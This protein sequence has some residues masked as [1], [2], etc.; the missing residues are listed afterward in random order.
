MPTGRLN[1]RRIRDV[2][3]LKL[4]QGLSDRSV[5]ASLGLSKGSV[6]SY[7]QRARD[8]GLTWPLPEGL[9]APGSSVH[10]ASAAHYNAPMGRSSRPQF[11]PRSAVM[12]KAAR[13]R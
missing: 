12:R 10:A 9:V 8:A 2:L 1:M 6:G 11:S 5:A 7:T 3:R 13:S 4:G